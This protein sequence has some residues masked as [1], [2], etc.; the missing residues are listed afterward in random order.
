MITRR[1][2]IISAAFGAAAARSVRAEGRYRLEKLV[3]SGF[4]GVLPGDPEVDV[5]RRLLE[6]DEIA[7]VI[8]LRRNIISPEQLIKLSLSLREAAGSFVPIISVDQEGGVVARV[9]AENGFSDWMSAAEAAFLLRSEQEIFDYYLARTR[10]LAGVGINV[11]FG[12]VLDLNLNPMN[13]IIGRL[14]RS[15]GSDPEVVV[16]CAS[17]FVR[18]HRATGIMTCGKHFPG[19]GSSLTDSHAE[20]TDVN[21]TWMQEELLPFQSMASA[22]LL[23]SVMSA[24]LIHRRFS[25]EDGLPVSLSKMAL[26]QLETDVGFNGPVFTDDMQMGAIT[27]NFSQETAS[28]AAVAAGNTFLIYANHA[29]EHDAGTAI[30]VNRAVGNALEVGRIA[31]PVFMARLAKATGFLK[32]LS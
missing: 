31:E 2:F 28:I 32:Q 24:H 13:P 29:Q 12:P 15:F 27:S 10:E 26:D 4:R 8:L 25:G 19:H 9:D 6:A 21:A 16:R 30:R 14:D 23:D 11:N 18:A 20:P 5:I 1:G 7:G 22:R 3:V 17:A